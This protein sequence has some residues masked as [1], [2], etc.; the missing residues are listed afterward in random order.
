MTALKPL[1][2]TGRGSHARTL[3]GAAN[4]ACSRPQL[5][6]HRCP[7]RRFY[8]PEVLHRHSKHTMDAPNMQREFP[9]FRKGRHCEELTRLDRKRQ[10]RDQTQRRKARRVPYM[11]RVTTVA[12]R[13]AGRVVQDAL[14]PGSRR[15][16]HTFRFLLHP[17]QRRTRPDSEQMNPYYIIKDL[18]LCPGPAECFCTFWATTKPQSPRAYQNVKDKSFR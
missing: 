12:L 8:N 3:V 6:Q 9:K 10:Y 17:Y 5:A 11:K 13:A 14:R 2:L 18:G 15:P 4:V 1:H 16:L 7:G